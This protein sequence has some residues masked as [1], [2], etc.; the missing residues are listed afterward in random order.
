[1]TD[2]EERLRSRLERLDGAVPEPSHPAHDRPNAPT[3]AALRNPR[4]RGRRLVVLL[5]AAV[6]I[7]GSSAVAADR[8]L[9]AEEVPYPEIEAAL[10][11]I[12][13]DRDCINAAAA[14]GLIRAELDALGY[15]GWGIESWSGADDARCVGAGVIGD[16][17]VVALF[18]GTG[19]ELADALEAAG[20]ELL[21]QCLD[22]DEAIA[23]L[24]SVITAAGETEFTVEADPWGPEGAPTDQYEAYERHAAEGCYV[25]VPMVGRDEDGRCG[26]PGGI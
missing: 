3:G 8:L 11:G 5:A 23:Y 16:H 24:S 26:P 25:R 14:S 9:F 19:Q 21:R 13:A 10:G 1:M 20:D 6:L 2:F 17:H 18:P 4:R 22:R 7:L 15:A 12:F